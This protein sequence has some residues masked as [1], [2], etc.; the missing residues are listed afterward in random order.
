M[1]V[2]SSFQEGDTKGLALFLF[3]LS[4]EFGDLVSQSFIFEF[5]YVYIGNFLLEVSPEKTF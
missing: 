1:C 2:S 5:R 3:S 4:F